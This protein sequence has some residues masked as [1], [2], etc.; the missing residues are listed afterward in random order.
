MGIRG[1]LLTAL[2]LV[3]GGVAGWVWA[4]LSAAPA[5]RDDAPSPVAAADPAIPYTPPEKV[6]KDSDLPPLAAGVATHE[7]LVGTPRSGGIATP[8]PN[9]WARTTL[10]GVEAKW[11]PANAPEGSYTVRVKRI[12]GENRTLPQKVAELIASL[13][14]DPSVTDVQIVDQSNDTLR[15]TFIF[16]GYRRFNVVRWVS[17]RGGLVDV[18]ISATGRLVDQPGLESLVSRIAT[19]VRLQTRAD[20]PQPGAQKPGAETPSSTS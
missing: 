19:E 16:D 10:P 1:S 8:V 18:E 5:L 7:E 14:F 12:I 2:L 11:A 15:S 20:R 13:P 6:K 9:G 4:D 17:F 3:V